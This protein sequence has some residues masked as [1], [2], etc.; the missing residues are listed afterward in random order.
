MVSMTK[1][2]RFISALTCL[3]FACTVLLP[4]AAMARP[5]K[6]ESL[7]AVDGMSPTPARVG[8]WHRV[9]RWFK[10]DWQ[11]TRAEFTKIRQR[12]GSWRRRLVG[13]EGQ[14]ERLAEL[15]ALL[16]SAMGKAMDEMGPRSFLQA[17]EGAAGAPVLPGLSEDLPPHQ[18]RGALLRG[19]E[20]DFAVLAPQLLSDG[21]EVE[22]AL[23]RAEAMVSDMASGDETALVV[24]R[25]LRPVMAGRSQRDRGGKFFKATWK[26][27]RT[28]FF[29]VAL[30]ALGM[31]SI[32]IIAY[33]LTVEFFAFT[34]VGGALAIAC[35]VGIVRYVVRCIKELQGGGADATP[36]PAPDMTGAE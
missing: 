27:L 23:D 13:K 19:F 33:G 3:V 6:V 2:L 30:G 25:H 8:F 17:M 5:R 7:Q 34:A 26:V 28:L 31:I 22:E 32:G 20:K 10:K 14:E 11:R 29:C 18:L 16:S 36:L 21:S 1:R 24:E 35:L 4:P 12:I 9:G 15:Q